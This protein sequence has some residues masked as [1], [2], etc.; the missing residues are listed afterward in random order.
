MRPG[1]GRGPDAA[2]NG[3]VRIAWTGST[4]Q[5]RTGLK[6]RPWRQVA[7]SHRGSGGTEGP[8]GDEGGGGDLGG[9]ALE[10]GGRVVAVQPDVHVGHNVGVSLQLEQALRLLQRLGRCGAGRGVGR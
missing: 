2:G 3:K 5:A 7:P 4:R 6:S 9:G 8:G 1:R 10:G